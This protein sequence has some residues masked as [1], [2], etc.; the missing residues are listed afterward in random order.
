MAVHRFPLLR[1]PRTPFARPA[2]FVPLAAGILLLGACSTIPFHHVGPTPWEDAAGAVADPALATFCAD[3]W[4][5]GLKQSPTWATWLGDERHHGLLGDGSAMGIERQREA[6][7]AFL[8]RLRAVGSDQ[9][10]GEDATTHRLLLEELELEAAEISLG[11][12]VHTWNVDARSGPQVGFLALAEVQPTSTE[13]QREQLLERWSAMGRAIDHRIAALRRGLASGRQAS[14]T[15]VARVIEQLDRLLATPIRSSPL[16]EVTYGGGRWVTLEPGQFLA[17]Y[18]AQEFGNYERATDLWRA[19]PILDPEALARGQALFVPAADDLLS[20]GERGHFVYGVLEEV[21]E[22]IRPAFARY[23]RFL[24]RELLPR[25]RPDERPGVKYVRGGSAWYRLC[26][27]RHT[28]LRVTPRR[29]HTTGQEELTRIHREMAVVGARLFGLETVTAIGERLRTD[30]ELFFDSAQEIE[31]KARACLARA[32]A[33]AQTLF[34]RLPKAPC[35][36][37]PIPAHEAP[38]TTIAYYRPP[39]PDGGRP[40]QYMINTY[41]ASTRP[42]YEA[43]VL[44]WHEAVPGHHLQ[45]ALSQELEQLP[46]VRRHGGSSAFV[47]GWALYTE[48]LADEAGLYTGDLDRLGMLSFDAWR[49]ARLVVD[50]GLHQYGWSRKKAIDFLVAN[51]F[52]TRDNATNEVDRYIAWPGQA[53]AYKV[54]QLEIRRLRRLAEKE[55]GE[56]FNLAAFHDTLLSRGA[57]TLP[58]LT[59]AVEAWIARRTVRTRATSETSPAAAPPAVP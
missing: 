13:R 6:V 34:G 39:A 17:A 57:V 15:A 28:G 59:E 4:E 7:G 24:A 27:R 42:R 40:G 49:A 30:P 8:V 1:A 20:P 46:L 14:H 2:P 58:V 22:G 51:T 12:D 48:R 33:A 21:R 50:T 29:I 5:H 55:L 54:G 45:I 26:I 25:A 10:D 41:Q 18:A 43:E 56:A 23:R 16:A 38:E 37:T 32:N 31:A 11:I 52:L 53:L 9:L 3:L 19:N 35:I 44:A 47:E 36:V